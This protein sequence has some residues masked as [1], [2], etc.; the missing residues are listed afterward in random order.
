MPCLW[1]VFTQKEDQFSSAEFKKTMPGTSVPCF[2]GIILTHC[3][4]WLLE[5]Y[6]HPG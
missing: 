3:E 4:E 6:R 5:M 2:Q 1:A